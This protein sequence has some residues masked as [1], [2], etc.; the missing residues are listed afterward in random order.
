MSENDNCHCAGTRKVAVKVME[1]TPEE[2][3]LDAT[4]E[5][6]HRGCRHN[7][8]GQIKSSQVAFNL[9]VTSAQ[10]YNKK[11]SVQCC[12]E[13]GQQLSQEHLVL[14]VN[15]LRSITRFRKI[16]LTSFATASSSLVLITASH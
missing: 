16:I 1:R 12:S 7:M 6:R 14:A 13:Y 3:S 10:S 5:N 15:M 4:S 11:C 9:K 2:E 8:L